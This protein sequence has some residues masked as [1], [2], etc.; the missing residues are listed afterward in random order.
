M[1]QLP[2]RLGGSVGFRR[3]RLPLKMAARLKERLLL[4]ERRAAG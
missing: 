2:T 4:P 3:Q 1:A